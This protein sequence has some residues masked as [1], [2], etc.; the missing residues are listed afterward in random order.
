MPLTSGVHR[1]QIS[2]LALLA[3]PVELRRMLG[4][5]WNDEFR[6]WQKAV[7]ANY[8]HFTTGIEKQLKKKDSQDN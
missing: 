7:V 3:T 8:Q 6:K 2:K 1:V 4:W 5:M